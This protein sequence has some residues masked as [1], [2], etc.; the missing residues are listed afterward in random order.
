MLEIQENEDG[1]VISVRAQA[2]ARRN[3]IAGVHAGMLKI[4]VTQVP[5]NGKA[6][7]AIA[8]LLAK[9]LKVSKS[10]VQLLSG[11]TNSHKRF[12]IQGVDRNRLQDLLDAHSS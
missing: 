9:E 2:G 3:G 4:A 5:E 1:V 10:S 11:A 6:N 12:A 8:N 7:Q